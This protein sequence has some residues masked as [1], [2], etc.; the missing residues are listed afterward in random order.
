MSPLIPC[1][2]PFAIPLFGNLSIHMFGI[3]VALGF[4]LGGNLAQRKAARFGV[5]PEFINQLIG[6]L[7]LGT[8]VGGH[9]GHLIFYEPFRLADDL[10][11]IASGSFSPLDLNILQVW[12]GL[13]SYGGFLACIPITIWFF[14][15]YQQPYWQHADALAIGFA[16]GWFFG[17]MGC[18]SAH[19]HPGPISDFFLAVPGGCSSET[20]KLNCA[21][22]CHDMGLY[23]ALW[24]GFT[25]VLFEVLDRRPRFTGFYVGLLPLMYGP[26]RFMSD[27]LRSHPVDVRYFG[28]TPAQYGSVI[29]SALGVWI[30]YSRSRANQMPGPA[31]VIPPPKKTA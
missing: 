13:S 6:W 3:L 8:F 25:W 27:F 9:L 15:K 18:F 31:F 2:E 12:H 22:A 5:D 20:G 24:S 28:L 14:R 11:T 1:F 7:V 10:K 29:L 4:L 16:L 21:V 17:R 30:L 23:E 19:D 26:Y